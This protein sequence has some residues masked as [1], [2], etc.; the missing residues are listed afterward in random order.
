MRWQEIKWSPRIHSVG[1]ALRKARL[2]R[3][4]YYVIFVFDY[5]KHRSANREFQKRHPDFPTPP[6]LMTFETTITSDYE[7][8]RRSGIDQCQH[9]LGIF[10]KVGPPG[11]ARVYEWG[12]GV[13][14]I[15]R[16]MPELGKERPVTAFGSDYAS[17]LVRWCRDN[18][19]HVEFKDNSLAPPL[20]YADDEFDFAYSVSVM[21]HLSIGLQREWVRENLRIVRP[22]GAVLFTVH[23]ESYSDR[24]TPPEL[25]Q[26]RTNGAVERSGVKD[27]SPWFTSY[28]SPAWI[29]NDL[30]GGL[31]VV[32]R[33]LTTDF[34]VPRQDIWVVRSPSK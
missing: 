12:C 14:R 20:P 4:L 21:T 6:A 19:P 16:H 8:Y 24:L 26:Y 1:L 34:A 3:P 29:E 27:G 10:D 2:L 23:G 17:D 30:L 13:G 18:I 15:I 32:Y 7:N 9:F 33:E 5:L 25:E 31:E 11:P 28:N 22:G